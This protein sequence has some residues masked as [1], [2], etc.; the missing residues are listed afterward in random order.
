MDT[1]PTSNI[2]QAIKQYRALHAGNNPLYCIMSAEEADELA[3]ILKQRSGQPHNVIVTTYQDIT[4][5]RNEFMDRGQYFL[6]N[7]LPETGS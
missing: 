2:D 7:E 3:D 1:T 6:S 4:M 5:I